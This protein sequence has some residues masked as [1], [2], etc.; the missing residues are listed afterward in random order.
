MLRPFVPH[1]ILGAAVMAALTLLRPAD[2]RSVG[3]ER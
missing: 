3:V 1:C 2:A